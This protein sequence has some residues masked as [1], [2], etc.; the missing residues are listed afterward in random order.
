LINQP[1]QH[2]ASRQWLSVKGSRPSSTSTKW[3]KSTLDRTFIPTESRRAK[4]LLRYTQRIAGMGADRPDNP[5]ARRSRARN[6]TFQ[7]TPK[8]EPSNKNSTDQ[9][10]DNSS[11]FPFRSIRLSTRPNSQYPRES[12]ISTIKPVSHGMRDALDKKPLHRD[13]A[14]PFVQY[15]NSILMSCFAA[16]PQ[17]N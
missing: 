1:L 8:P 10:V 15:N 17:R 3:R 16:S 9:R 14:N 11:G 7:F 2:G 5:V 4:V 12:Y 6:R 13:A